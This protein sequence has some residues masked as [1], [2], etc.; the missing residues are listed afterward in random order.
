MYLRAKECL[1]GISNL[2][3]DTSFLGSDRLIET[4][5]QSFT[6]LREADFPQDLRPDFRSICEAI[7]RHREIASTDLIDNEIENA[8]IVR[9]IIRL[10]IAL[11]A[12]A[13]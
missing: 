13:S 3:G 8:K 12:R 6:A 9:Q 11:D 2:L 4:L 10:R 7:S 5:A 1:A